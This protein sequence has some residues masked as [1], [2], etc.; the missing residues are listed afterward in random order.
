MIIDGVEFQEP[1]G[2]QLMPLQ[3][4]QLAAGVHCLHGWY[5]DWGPSQWRIGVQN[6]KLGLTSY[7]RN[8]GYYSLPPTP[9]AYTVDWARRRI[10]EGLEGIG[11]GLVLAAF[12]S[13]APYNKNAALLREV[14]FGL[15]G[16]RCY[17]NVNYP[18]AQ[19]LTLPK[20][21]I[22]SPDRYPHWIHIWI[23]DL[24]GLESCGESLY[25]RTPSGPNAAGQASPEYAV[26]PNCCGLRVCWSPQDPK[27]NPYQPAVQPRQYLA[28][29]Q[30]PSAQK[31]PAKLGW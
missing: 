10:Q 17:P 15:L 19:H 14:G 13:F 20:G 26:F 8:P 2:A 21:C 25:G 27:P 12:P 9:V 16:G 23:K 7:K 31:F 3:I 22:Y 1:V 5:Q 30:I 6:Y 28:V 11:R 29:C 4:T 18:V 24:G